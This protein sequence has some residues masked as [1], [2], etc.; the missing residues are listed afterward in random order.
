MDEKE[1]KARIK[2]AE[3]LKNSILEFSDN[4]DQEHLN[5]VFQAME[6]LVLKAGGLLLAADPAGDKEGQRQITL[7][8]LKTEDGKREG[9]TEKMQML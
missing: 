7:K 2:M 1:I 5:Q 3:G 4:R 9:K 6:D 8:F